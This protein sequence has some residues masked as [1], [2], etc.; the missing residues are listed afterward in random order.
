MGA[1]YNE[2]KARRFADV[3]VRRSIASA[4]RCTVIQRLRLQS[5]RSHADAKPSMHFLDS[6]AVVV[7]S[8]CRHFCH[9]CKDGW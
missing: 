3:T 9:F 8:I 5:V 4:I 7:L 2:L 1:S 6:A